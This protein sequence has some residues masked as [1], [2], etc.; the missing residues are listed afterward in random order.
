MGSAAKRLT[1][2]FEAQFDEQGIGRGLRPRILYP[3]D[4]HLPGF[5]VEAAIA[6]LRIR[7]HLGY[8]TGRTPGRKPP[9]RLVLAIRTSSPAHPMLES[10]A[11][12]TSDMTVQSSLNQTEEE[13]RSTVKPQNTSG[14][15]GAPDERLVHHVPRGTYFRFEVVGEEVHVTFLPKAMGLL[16]RECRVEWVDWYR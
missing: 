10:F 1:A 14:T 12:I 13:I 15:N 5:R 4:P 6:T 16:Q 11:L 9:D 3:Y 8:I 2:S 7:P